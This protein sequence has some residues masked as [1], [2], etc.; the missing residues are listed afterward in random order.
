ME[1]VKGLERLLKIFTE[2]FGENCQGARDIK[3]IIKE[4]ESVVKK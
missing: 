2:K 1:D 4:K 3:K